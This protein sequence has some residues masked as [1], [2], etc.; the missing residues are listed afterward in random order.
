MTRSIDCSLLTAQCTMDIEHYSA[1]CTL[2]TLHT[3]RI[4][5]STHS[6]H[7]NFQTEYCI[8]YTAHCPLTAAHCKLHTAHFTLHTENCTL[9]IVYCAMRT[10]NCTLHNAYYTLN[11]VDRKLFIAHCTVCP[12][13]ECLTRTCDISL[14][15]YNM[16][17]MVFDVDP[18]GLKHYSVRGCSLMTS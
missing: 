1:Q 13:S 14:L 16:R 12:L 9:H 15:F 11:I 5:H 4:L 2:T 8:L 6:A 17:L 18:L 7:C 3:P 10:E